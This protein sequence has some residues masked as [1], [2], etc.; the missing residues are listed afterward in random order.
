M[1][2]AF[3]T[4]MGFNGKIPRTHT[5]MRTEYA[6][7]VAL[8]ADHYNLQQ[9]PKQSYDLGIV[10]NSKNNPEQVDVQ[11]Y[12][13]KCK[14]VAVMQEGPFWYFQD[15][16]L[17]NQVHYFNNLMAADIILVHNKLDADYFKGLTDHPDVRVLRSL[18]IEDPI[19]N[20]TSPEERSGVMIGGNFKSWYGGFDS[21]MLA[22]SI[23]EEIYSPQ[24][25]RR[26]EGEE[27]LG[28][29]QLPYLEWNQ[30]ISELSK[31]RI[32]IH[33]M[34]TH[35]AG[36]FAMNCSYL[37]IPC[38]GY[39]GLDTQQILHPE[40][41]VR[42]GDLASARK[43]IKKLDNDQEFYNLCIDQTLKLYKQHYH[44]E[45]FNPFI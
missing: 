14:Q 18:M 35:A 1:E 39:A 4:E 7:M 8:G 11:R 13:T 31:R 40:L 6:W 43:L 37:G 26:Q 17:N 33:M 12:K 24:M 41:T 34:R 10:I 28:I 22:K 19:S 42:D 15:F 44:E 45:S 36:T 20:V 3:F 32:G 5:N 9:T 38:I 25:G 30:W 27:Q 29:T 21:F 2:V 23:T 16:P